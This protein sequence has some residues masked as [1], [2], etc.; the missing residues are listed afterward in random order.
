ME[1]TKTFSKAGLLGYFVK[2]SVGFF[3]ACIAASIVMTALNTVIPKIIGFT[4]DSVLGDIPVPDEYGGIVGM[5]GGVERLKR[6]IW[7]VALVTVG[8]ALVTLIFRYCSTYFNHRADNTLMRRMRNTLFTHIQR[9]P[10]SWHSKN[11]TGDIIQRCTSD[12]DTISN[13]VSGQLVSLVR[14]MLL[15]T[16]SLVFM[17]T[18]DVRLAAI[19]SAFIPPIIGYSLFYFFKAHKAF[20]TCDEQEG[21]LSTYAQ[22]NLT[23]VRVVR[24]F[25]RER[26]E[27]DKF[28]KQNSHYTGLW[29]RL[30][31]FMALYWTSSDFIVALQLLFIIVLGTLF[32]VRGGMTAG[33]LV[34]FISYNT[35]MMGPVRQL[36]RIIS[37]LSKANVSLGRLAEVMNAEEEVYGEDEGALAGDIVFENVGFEYEAGKPVLRGVSFAVPQGTTLGIVGGTGSGKSTVACLMDGLYAPTSGRIT[38]GGRDIKDIPPATLRRNVGFV[39]Q[40]GY[41]YSRTIAENIAIAARDGSAENVA[42]AAATACL[43]GNVE[44]FANGYETVVGERGVTLSGGQK[45]RVAIAR[46]IIRETPYMIFDDSL[47]AVDSDTDA[48]IRAHLR[49][50]CKGVTTVI[51]AHRLTTVMH[52]DNIIV[53]DGG[54]I[55]EHG[56]H[57]ELLERDGIYKRIYDV[58]LSLPDELKEEAEHAR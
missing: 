46:T 47:S 27:R 34:A 8:I 28:E 21:V 33:D 43:D 10:L 56:S 32:C 31:K 15:L 23:G 7:I 20:K 36:G 41:I 53:M 35:M 11:N 44:G 29:V 14:I 6:D 39:M 55:A 22:E 57:K 45:Q 48:R 24:A 4:I 30:N 16:L 18:T 12:A 26:Y 52:A 3:V 49:K 13:F 40:E 2:G 51:I 38:I 37:N 1:K 5:F 25:G 50:E 54:R 17:F 19:A 58:Q 42:K 9:L